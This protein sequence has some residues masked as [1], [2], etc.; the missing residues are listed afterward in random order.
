[1]TAFLA[2][3]A[4]AIW[5]ASRIGTCQA[6]LL[7]LFP[8]APM[9]WLVFRQRG[10]R[11]FQRALLMLVLSAAGIIT[12]VLSVA[13]LDLLAR[14]SVAE[15][16]GASIEVAGQVNWVYESAY[17][18]QYTIGK[19]KGPDGKSLKGMLLI[20]GKDMGSSLSEG[21]FPGDRIRMTGQIV[22][23]EGR[24][25]PGAFDQ[26]SYWFSKGVHAR[27]EE[28]VLVSA[29]R[30]FAGPLREAAWAFSSSFKS[31]TDEAMGKCVSNPLM[32]AIA[33]SD[34][35][36]LDP[37]VSEAFRKG[38]IAHVMS[39]SG[40]H[41]SIV[42]AF[43]SFMLGSSGAPEWLCLL[44]AGS[45]LPIYA[46]AAGLRPSIIRACITGIGASA[47]KALKL[48]R[49][50]QAG[51]LLAA[52]SIQVTVSP[53][54]LFDAG[55][56]MSYL[57]VIG[58]MAASALFR[59]D[60]GKTGAGRAF[61]R[62]AFFAL[63]G[64]LMI[65]AAL[66]PIISSYYGYSSILSPVTNLVA[67]P[68]ASA[69]LTLGL[70]GY[71]A[72]WVSPGLGSLIV[73]PAKCLL[74]MLDA[75]AGPISRI[76][77]LLIPTGYGNGILGALYL[78]VITFAWV[79]LMGRFSA[80]RLAKRCFTRLGPVIPAL[81]AALLTASLM[82]PQDVAIRVLSVGQG[83][84]ILISKGRSFHMLVDTGPGFPQGTAMEERI[85]P[86]LRSIGVD[87]IDVLALTHSHSDH[88]SGLDELADAMRIGLV[89]VADGD[90]ETAGKVLH[91][92]L[93]P[94][95]MGR[96]GSI[97][98]GGLVIRSINQVPSNV[99]VKDANEPSMVLMIGYAGQNALLCA[100]AGGMFESAYSSGRAA[101]I[102]IGH[103]GSKA[104]SSEE[105]LNKLEAADAAISVGANFYG[106]PSSEAIER[107]LAAGMSIRR[108]D[109]DGMI[110]AL[111]RADGIFV[112]GE[113][114]SWDRMPFF[115][116]LK[117]AGGIGINPSLNVK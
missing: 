99:S 84:S 64:S 8:A 115:R 5:A 39:A 83:D 34:K 95:F 61:V 72:H 82:V 96:G 85:L 112:S 75:M 45:I 57:A 10:R 11:D 27:L 40:L 73:L 70:A 32:D 68:S 49:P 114:D 107:I 14:G 76:E 15:L 66:L 89:L 91:A 97:A 36:E 63:S 78:G 101:F 111:M 23:M 81:T 80:R 37:A 58:I 44:M 30:G 100:D 52:A 55:F 16:K 117:E 2:S 29:A 71:L 50:D 74:T 21:L 13:R 103:H 54:S 9:L 43:M 93:E 109:C 26:R 17:G 86:A 94:T 56:Q 92:G 1:M 79:C 62:Q 41:V 19:L 106:H 31:F 53:M 108:T 42:M 46:I 102:K 105:F 35:S 51:L 4:A 67:I 48:K 28:A 38:G 18:L 77:V 20:N 110:T 60:R 33:L 25:N 87:S 69:A 88:A 104:S 22:L 12:G 47:V 116:S 65:S 6:S 98:S 7:L 3:E 90:Y 59:D 113:S 24:M